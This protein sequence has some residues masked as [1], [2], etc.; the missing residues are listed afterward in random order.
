MSHANIAVEVNGLPRCD[1]RRNIQEILHRW[2]VGRQAITMQQDENG[3]ARD[4]VEIAFA[5]MLNLQLSVS[6]CRSAPARRA[7]L[8]P[9]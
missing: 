8:T 1:K 4:G 3:S 5:T 7:R 2:E 9:I 6:R